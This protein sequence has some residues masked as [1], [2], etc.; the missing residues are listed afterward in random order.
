MERAEDFIARLDGLGLTHISIKRATYAGRAARG[1]DLD[2]RC[3]ND[4]VYRLRQLRTK[5]RLKLAPMYDFQRLDSMPD[6]TLAAL[7][8]PPSATNCG[9]GTAKV[10]VYTNG[11]VCP[12]TCFKDRP[13]GNLYQSG[14]EQILSSP[15]CIE[16]THPAC[17]ACRYFKLCRGGCLGSGYQTSGVLGT[18]DPRCPRLV[19]A[20][21]A[22]AA[23]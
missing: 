17:T 3:W 15:P 7:E 11:D 22:G 14:L 8:L 10:Y 5:T 18:P 20:R 9:A 19:E 2:G 6:S 12:C 23:M 1:I 21:A 16:V 13:M 4:H